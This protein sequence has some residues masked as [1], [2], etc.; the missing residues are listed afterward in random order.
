MDF[1]INCIVYFAI[2]WVLFNQAK[3]TLT[4]LTPKFYSKIES[5]VCFKCFTF[6]FTLIITWFNLPVAA[7]ASLMAYFFDKNNNV[8]L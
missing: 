2:A 6:W 8:E 5:F 4:K 7:V 3:I 1:L